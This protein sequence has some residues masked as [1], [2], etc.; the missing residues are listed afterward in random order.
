MEYN[1]QRS[2]SVFRVLR[3]QRRIIVVLSLFCASFSHQSP[4]AN[5]TSKQRRNTWTSHH[6]IPHPVFHFSLHALLDNLEMSFHYI[7][8]IPPLTLKIRPFF[9]LPLIFYLFGTATIFM[10]LLYDLIYLATICG[11]IWAT[12]VAI[13]I[14][15]TGKRFYK[16][17]VAR[18]WKKET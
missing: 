16:Q 1:A 17:S 12:L 10:F 4:F 11:I 18:N 14:N 5:H 6:P 13:S 7:K 9:N 8:N 15:T 3:S 2:K